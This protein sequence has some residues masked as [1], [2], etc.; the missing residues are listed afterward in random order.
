MSPLIFDHQS[1]NIRLKLNERFLAR[2]RAKEG[3]WLKHIVIC[4]ETWVHYK[5]LS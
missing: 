2:Y 4:N 3:D 5:L 1:E